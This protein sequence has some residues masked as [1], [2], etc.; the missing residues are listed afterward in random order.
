MLVYLYTFINNS[1]FN[2]GDYKYIDEVVNIRVYL[3]LRVSFLV[4]CL[5]LAI[6]KHSLR[7]MRITAYYIIYRS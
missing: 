7:K 5:F 3:I 1:L 6:L 4:A 2:R